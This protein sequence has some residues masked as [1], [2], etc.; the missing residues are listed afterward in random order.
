MRGSPSGTTAFEATTRAVRTASVAPSNPAVPLDGSPS[1][2]SCRFPIP[3]N[4]R[5]R[6]PL[7]W[8]GLGVGPGVEVSRPAISREI[9]LPKSATD[10]AQASWRNGGADSAERPRR[11]THG[12]TT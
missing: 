6:A 7:Y 8:G 1:P 3:A 9:K 5:R 4:S 10:R 12:A 2:V 11:L